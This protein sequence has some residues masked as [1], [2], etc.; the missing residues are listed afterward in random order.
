MKVPVNK[1]IKTKKSFS[2]PLEI[3]KLNNNK[4]KT[5][6]A[7]IRLQIVTVFGN[8]FEAFMTNNMPPINIIRIDKNAPRIA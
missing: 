7:L 5:G 3:I 8:F 1:Y 4:N 2:S 6:E